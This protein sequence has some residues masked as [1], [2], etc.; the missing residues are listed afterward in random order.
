MLLPEQLAPDYQTPSRMEAKMEAIRLPNLASKRVLDIGC[1]MGFWSFLAAKRGANRVLGLDRNRHVR[2]RG[3]TNL[4]AQNRAIAAADPIY[5]ACTFEWINLGKQW[6]RFGEFDVVL[7]LSMYHHWFEQCG[8]HGAIWFWLAQHC[9]S[10]AALIYEGPLDDRD[11]VVRANV[12]DDNRKGFTREAIL[13]AA[14]RYFDPE[15]VGPA[16]H[17]P[18]REVWRFRPKAKRE[19]L[20]DG[21][22]QAGAGGATAAFEYENGRRIREI[23]AALGFRAYPGSLNVEIDSP[24]DWDEGYYRAQV[25]DVAE[26]GRGLDVEWRPRW[27]RF[28]PLTINGVAAWAFRFEGEKYGSRFL[29][30]IAPQRLRDTLNGGVQIAR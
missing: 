17:E 28:Y 1:D 20:T 24:F 21:R 7:V 3:L 26:R 23:E 13:G 2:G 15:F 12:S 30:L 29:E 27:A 10:D 6:K 5:R 25:L 11:S 16:L 18:T 8:D 9:A 14:S 19:R 22:I 4:I